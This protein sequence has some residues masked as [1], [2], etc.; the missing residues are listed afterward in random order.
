[1]DIIEWHRQYTTPTTVDRNGFLHTK[2]AVEHMIRT[3]GQTLV[4]QTQE[5]ADLVARVAVTGLAG[6]RVESDLDGS[7]Y[8]IT[9]HGREPFRVEVR[10]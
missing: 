6:C 3:V 10:R 7:G 5:Q 1:M 8:T 4:C 2:D 9:A